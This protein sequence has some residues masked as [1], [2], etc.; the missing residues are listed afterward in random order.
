MY[1]RKIV[2]III[3]LILLSSC[4]ASSKVEPETCDLSEHKQV[5]DEMASTVEKLK[6]QIH[7]LGTESKPDYA[8]IHS[9]ISDLLETTKKIQVPKCLEKSK[10]LLISTIESTI[11]GIKL[12][13]AG[14]ST[15]AIN[16]INE[17]TQEIINQYIQELISVINSQSNK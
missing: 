6:E 17:N 14:E 1:M 16:H 10:E 3:A 15:K 4:S 13:Q 7:M 5:M 12:F 11:D 2:I 9:E 8:E